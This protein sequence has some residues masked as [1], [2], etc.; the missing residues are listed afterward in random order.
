MHSKSREEEGVAVAVVAVTG[1]RARENDETHVPIQNAVVA[2]DAVAVVVIWWLSLG[3]KMSPQQHK[4]LQ[5]MK[6]LIG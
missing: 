4:Q 5:M 3:L 1:Q 2:V 6:Q